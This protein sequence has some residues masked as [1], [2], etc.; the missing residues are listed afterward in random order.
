MIKK[1]HH[2]RGRGEGGVEA[3]KKGDLIL[4]PC[5]SDIQIFLQNLNICF[6][7]NDIFDTVWRG[8]KEVVKSIY[9]DI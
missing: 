9:L 1:R 2:K 4:C 5:Y 7:S 8:A 6:I 3:K